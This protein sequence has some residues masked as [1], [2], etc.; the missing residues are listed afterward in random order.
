M[1]TMTLDIIEMVLTILLAIYV[2][3]SLAHIKKKYLW[4]VLWLFLFTFME[5]VF[6][7]LVYVQGRP[8]ADAYN[9]YIVEETVLLLL[10]LA[11]LKPGVN[12]SSEVSMRMKG[13]IFLL[14]AFYFSSTIPNQFNSHL[15]AFCAL[16]LVL[17]YISIINYYIVHYSGRLSRQPE[18]MLSLGFLISFTFNLVYESFFMI[19]A[20]WLLQSE[21]YI[22][23]EHIFK[24]GWN[25][26]FLLRLAFVLYFF[27]LIIRKEKKVRLLESLISTEKK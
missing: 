7:T 16:I 11:A 3:S 12:F 6:N 10:G 20:D 1:D 4:I 14:F 24:M 18:F 9:L 19:L 8:N 22:P 25:C 5:I 26:I 23:V 13:F 15:T 21:R 27:Y 17:R 2:A